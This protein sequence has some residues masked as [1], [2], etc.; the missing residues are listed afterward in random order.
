M[1]TPCL[2]AIPRDIA[3]VSDYKPYARHSL[4][5]NA[6]AYLASG[7]ADELTY[8]RNRDAFDALRLNS[9]VLADLRGG[10]TRLDLFGQPLAHPILLAPVAY[11]RLFHNDG[12]LAAAQAAEALE[13]T[14]VVSTLASV[15]LEE[16][17]QATRAPLWFQLYIQPDRGYTRHLIERAEAAGYRALVVTV[18]APLSGLRNQEQR[19]GFHLPPGVDAANLRDMPAPSSP[20]A[21]LQ[22]GQSP[23]FDGLLATAPTWA[24]IAAIR[25]L[26]RLPLILKG[27]LSPRDARQALALGVDGL[28]VSNH[29]GRTIDTLPAAIDALPAVAEAVSGRIPLLLDGG[30]R[31]GSDIF[32]ALALG[33][34]AV[35]IGRPWVYG[36]AAAGP[37]G[38]AH[39][40][41]ILREE[42]EVVMALTGCARLD[43][44]GP[45]RLWP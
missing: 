36:L 11:Q 15:P 37:L 5:D 14:M 32:K 33:A 9:H 31:R 25:D 17:A 18:D 38:A 16:I 45:D 22:P 26:T 24:D 20:L 30:I 12:E 29:G 10:H 28:V 34:R 2:T 41:K 7:A 4:D 3:C 27:I 8:R 43:D 21:T 35:L 6:W 19:A 42:F 13:A 44:I 1:P 39:V 23:V 40:L